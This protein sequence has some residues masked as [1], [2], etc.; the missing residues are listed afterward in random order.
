MTTQEEQDTIAFYKFGYSCYAIARSLGLSYSTVR[1]F[2]ILHEVT[3]DEGAVLKSP[4]EN[5][6]L[7]GCLYCGKLIRADNT[8]IDAKYCSDS[9]RNKHFRVQKSEE[10]FASSP[11]IVIQYPKKR[12]VKDSYK[13]LAL[14]Q[15]KSDEWGDKEG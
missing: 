7:K 1:N 13:R 15:K 2:L 14:C 3:R 6:E 5:E 12:T 10:N 4:K 9:C 11:K 8:R